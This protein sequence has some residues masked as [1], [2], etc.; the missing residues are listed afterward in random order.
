MPTEHN[1]VR[2]W[3]HLAIGYPIYLRA[4]SGKLIPQD[5]AKL[6]RHWLKAQHDPER[7][8]T[9]KMEGV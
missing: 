5:A 6:I 7:S 3:A 8:L 2:P 9:T 4:I 1:H